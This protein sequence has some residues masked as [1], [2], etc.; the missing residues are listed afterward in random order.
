MTALALATHKRLVNSGVDPRSDEYY[1]RI[2]ARV[3]EKFPE[4][5]EKN[6]GD[7]NPAEQAQPH[8]K[9]ATVVAATAR[10]SSAK[11]ITLTQTQVN[12]AKKLGIPLA[13]YAKQVALLENR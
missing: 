4:N 6:S 2:D 10:S 9:P 7:D 5:F 3:R 12:L 8:R 13:D 11:K 1:K